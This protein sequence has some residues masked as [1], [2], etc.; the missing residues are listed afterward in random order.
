MPAFAQGAVAGQVLDQ[1]TLIPIEGIEVAVEGS[2]LTARTDDEGKF[3]ISKLAPGKYRIVFQSTKYERI[4]KE[5]Q[6][7]EAEESLSVELKAAKSGVELAEVKVSARRETVDIAKQSLNQEEIQ[8]VPGA[9][10][11]AMRVVESL[12]GVANIGV[13]SLGTPGLVIRGTG[14]EDSRYYLDGFDIP[15]LFHF[16]GLLTVVNSEWLESLDYYAG[17]YSVRYGNALGGIVELK[18]RPPNTEKFSG[19]A[20]LTNYASFLLA[21]SPFDKEGKWSGGI[22]ARRSFID[23]IL[24][25]FI[26]D[27]EASFT[28]VP[29]F[30]DFQ[31]AAMYQPSSVNSFRLFAFGSDDKVGLINNRADDYLPTSTQSID[32]EAWFYR[33]ILSWTYTPSADINNRLAVSPN[34]QS[35]DSHFMRDFYFKIGLQSVELRDDLTVK[36][37]KWNT[38]SLGANVAYASV[39][40][41]LNVMRPPKEGNPSGPEVLNQKSFLYDTHL[42]FQTVESYIEDSVRIADIFSITPGLRFAWGHFGGGGADSSKY[43][44]DPRVFARQYLTDKAALKA[45][46]GVYHQFPQP[47]EF[48]PPFGTLKVESEVAYAYGFGGEYDFPGG[49]HI[50]AQGYYKQIQDMVTATIT[51]SEEP[52]ENSG[53]GK[54]YGFELLARK[55]LTDRLYGWISYTYSVSRRRDLP[56]SDWRYFDQDQRHNFIILASYRLGETWRIGGRFSYA[57]GLPYTEIVSS[58]YNA[59]ADSFVPIFSEKINAERQADLHR[60]DVRVDKEWPFKSWKLKTYLDIQNV[61]AHKEPVGYL[62]N[63]NYTKK[64]AVSFPTFYPTLGIQARW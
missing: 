8:T 1:A 38:L 47:D 64:E 3:R 57:T 40:I 13:A 36:P 6:V 51:G 12:P 45:S 60:L 43:Y 58:I 10:A 20:D 53:I 35:V 41:E 14:P 32:F 29:R 34:L 23:F 2:D 55:D 24:P 22:T 63:Y 39:P 17:G 27:D 33:P 50:D 52:Y 25:E 61:Y 18:S 62:Y 54:I 44:I 7:G 37:A 28:M 11:D 4:V 59:D 15:Q 9:A 16:G 42:D 21:E 26:S 19:V 49:Y 30:Y 48:L 46:A 56:K 31:A 5:I